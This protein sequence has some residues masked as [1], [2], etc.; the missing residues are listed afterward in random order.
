[1]AFVSVT[2]VTKTDVFFNYLALIF[3]WENLKYLY[4][5]ILKGETV[6]FISERDGD[7]Q[8][9]QGAPHAL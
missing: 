3:L 6:Q 1:M 8:C 7:N 9:F 4:R 2:L 5:K